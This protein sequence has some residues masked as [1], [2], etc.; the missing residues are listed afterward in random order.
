MYKVDLRTASWTGILDNFELFDHQD[1]TAIAYQRFDVKENVR[2]SQ[3][4]TDLKI[5]TSAI[6]CK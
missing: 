2:L 1:K 6:K 5:I 4:P 3:R